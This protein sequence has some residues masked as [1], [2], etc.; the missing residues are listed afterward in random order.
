[1]CALFSGR[2]RGET[3][4]FPPQAV[5][6]LR[7]SQEGVVPSLK[8]NVWFWSPRK[9][10]LAFA[11]SQ[12]IFGRLR[13]LFHF[14][15]SPRALNRFTSLRRLLSTAH[16]HP[17]EVHKDHKVP[18]AS[19]T[20]APVLFARHGHIGEVIFNRPKALNALNLDMVRAL[21][22]QFRVGWNSKEKL[23]AAVWLSGA[24]GRAFCAGGDIKTLWE[25]RSSPE[26]AALQDSFFSEEYC[27]DHLLAMDSAHHRPH[28]A[29]YDGTVM[30][31]GVGVSI[32]AAFRIATERTTFAMP[33]TAIGFFPDV[34]EFL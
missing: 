28:I 26:G 14:S 20:D 21:D 23:L 27:V 11:S 10:R 16:H 13:M 17:R 7:R 19:A 9:K 29:V 25:G 31:G 32:H 4:T 1:M 34:G 8:L 33:E 30:G 24:G 18:A 6:G 3:Q 12:R 15:D 2:R 22:S 5:E